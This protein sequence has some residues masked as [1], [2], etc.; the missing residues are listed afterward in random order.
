MEIKTKGVEIFRNCDEKKLLIEINDYLDECDFNVVD[1]KFQV[2]EGESF[3]M[4]NA[5]VIYELD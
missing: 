2:T 5:M 3:V 4:Y 1:I